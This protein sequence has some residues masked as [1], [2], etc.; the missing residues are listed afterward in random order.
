MMT[1]LD[2]CFFVRIANGCLLTCPFVSHSEAIE[3]T[4]KARGVQEL[5][6]KVVEDLEFKMVSVY[7]D[8]IVRQRFLDH[9]RN[10]QDSFQNLSDAERQMLAQFQSDLQQLQQ[11]HALLEREMESKLFPWEREALYARLRAKKHQAAQQ[12]EAKLQ[13]HVREQAELA[14]QAQQAQLA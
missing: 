7:E 2:R 10:R 13:M 12:A 14:Q 5:Q 3:D 11:T 4:R 9:A 1:I 8:M 6:Q